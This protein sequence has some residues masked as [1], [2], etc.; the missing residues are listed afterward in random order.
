MNFEVV[1]LGNSSATP[2]AF[3]N[4]S[5]Q[6]VRLGQTDLLIDC[7]EAT[8]H[9]F[10]KYHLSMH[11][12]DIVLISHLH[13]D[14]FTGLIGMICTL[15]LQGRDS[16]LEIFGPRGIKEILEVQL[17]HAGAQLNYDLQIHEFDPSFEGLLKENTLLEINAFPLQ[18]RISCHGFLIRE[19]EHDRKIIKEKVKN[20]NWPHD[21]YLALKDGKEYELESGEILKPGDFTEPPPPPRSYAYLTDT[22]PQ[23][24]YVNK[25]KPVSLLYHESTFLET[26]HDKARRTFHSTAKEAAEFAKEVGADALILGHY[27]ARYGDIS[28]FETEAKEIFRSSHAAD[29]GETFS[30]PK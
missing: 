7:G 8:Q 13:P 2:T 1:I 21:A 28:A 23:F 18:H 4:N 20:V 11:K 6:L 3:R 24:Q 5:A 22:R 12:V 19:K 17:K 14:H 30:I 25:L 9:Q 27:S 15:N 10:I 29:E 16:E 26:E